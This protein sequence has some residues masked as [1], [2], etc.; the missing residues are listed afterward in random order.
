MVLHVCNRGSK[1]SHNCGG[2]KS[3]QAGPPPLP[4]SPRSGEWSPGRSSIERSEFLVSKKNTTSA[5]VARW[6]GAQKWTA[7][8]AECQ[9][10]DVRSV[11]LEG[12]YPHACPPPSPAGRGSSVTLT[13][14][15][16]LF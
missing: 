8:L 2:W 7:G 13:L 11:R 14:G 6:K 4:F 5:R 16:P 10:G 15:H 9:F 3:D 12:G 1:A